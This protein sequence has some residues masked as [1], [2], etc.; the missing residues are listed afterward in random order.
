MWIK[1]TVLERN[2]TVTKDHGKRRRGKGEMY[3]KNEDKQYSAYPE[4]DLGDLKGADRC[5]GPH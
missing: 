5:A 3:D 1:K 4:L 2:A